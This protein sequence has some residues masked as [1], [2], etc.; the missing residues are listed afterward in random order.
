[1]SSETNLKSCEISSRASSSSTCLETDDQELSP[2]SSGFHGTGFIG[3]TKEAFSAVQL[4]AQTYISEKKIFELF[5]FLVG[6][7]LVDEPDDPVEYIT[8]LLERCALF[9]SG[10]GDAPVLFSQRHIETMFQSMDLSCKGSIT[11]D[12]YE[13]GM[14]SLGIVNYEK[15]PAESAPGCVDKQ[16]FLDNA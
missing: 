9:R 7:L 1:M 15:E 13:K 8:D 10:L 3:D 16:T 4:E 2:S 12:Q 6:H 11:L 14:K 5:N